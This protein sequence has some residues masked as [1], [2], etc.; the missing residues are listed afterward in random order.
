MPSMKMEAMCLYCKHVAQ[1]ILAIGYY[2][3]NNS[4]ER[5]AVFY[6]N[7]CSK[8]ECARCE[9]V[10]TKILLEQSH[11]DKLNKAITTTNP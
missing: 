7:W 1:N 9:R 10:L 5:K 2:C 11:A 3:E 4:I 6:Y 8:R